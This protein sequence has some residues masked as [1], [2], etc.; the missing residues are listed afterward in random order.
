MIVELQLVEVGISFPV[1][2]VATWTASVKI[3]F[4]QAL[5][6]NPVPLEGSSPDAVFRQGLRLLKV[7]D[8]GQPVG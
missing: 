7:V 6:P 1:S 2:S 4:F 8:D 5:R 3:G